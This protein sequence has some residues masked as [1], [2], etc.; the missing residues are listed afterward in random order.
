M[1][2]P[3]PDLAGLI[4]KMKAGD[5]FAREELFRQAFSQLERMSRKRLDQQFGRLR[6]RGIETGDVLNDALLQVV[7]RLE[8]GSDLERLS[9]ERDF[10]VMIA[11]HIRWALLN[12]AKRLA[13]Q[14]EALPQGAFLAET[15]HPFS[16]EEMTA[17]HTAVDNLPQEQREVFELLYFSERT[18]EEAAELLGV[19]RDTVKRRYSAA[20]DALKNVLRN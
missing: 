19:H 6:F 13:Q 18:Y 3:R 8:K 7:K 12:T 17:F 2:E 1:D 10:F 15:V 9:S 20:K 4:N 16:L 11:Q 5:P 14:G